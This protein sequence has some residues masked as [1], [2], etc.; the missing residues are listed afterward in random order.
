MSIGRITPQ[1]EW[2][3]TYGTKHN[4][5]EVGSVTLEINKRKVKVKR[6]KIKDIAQGLAEVAYS[7]GETNDPDE[8]AEDI[9]E[10]ILE[11]LKKAEGNREQKK[12]S[13]NP[14]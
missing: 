14:N 2:E 10:D 11:A 8:Y 5:A 13:R 9:T 1:S 3:N 12:K 4:V 6:A 7:M